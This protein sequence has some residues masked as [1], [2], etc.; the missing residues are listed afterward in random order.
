MYFVSISQQIAVFSLYIIKRVVF[1]TDAESVY[2][3]VR[4]E[5]LSK[6]FSFFFKGRFM[7]R[8]L[9]A[10]LSLRRPGFYPRLIHVKF[11]GLK[12]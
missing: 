7:A 6:T 5:S 2:C 1:K 12:T 3:A 9:V 8:R 11:V 4:I 10:G